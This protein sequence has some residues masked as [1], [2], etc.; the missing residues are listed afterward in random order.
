MWVL[1]VTTLKN[2]GAEAPTA[3]ILTRPLLQN[4]MWMEVLDGVNQ[5]SERNVS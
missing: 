1:V 4:L 5:R 3:P 2:V